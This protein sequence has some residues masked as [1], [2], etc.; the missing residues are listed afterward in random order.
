MNDY[1]FSNLS[2][3][4]FEVL[5]RDLLRADLGMELQSFKAGRDEGIDLLSDVSNN[6]LFLDPLC[7]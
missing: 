3:Y 2:G 4:E 5:V 6:K 1:D 7:R